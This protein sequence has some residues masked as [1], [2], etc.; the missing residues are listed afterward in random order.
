MQD[1]YLGL[2]YLLITVDIKR[3]LLEAATT[4]RNSL[5]LAICI[6]KFKPLSLAAL[7]EDILTDSVPLSGDRLAITVNMNYFYC[8]INCHANNSLVVGLLTSEIISLSHY[9]G[10]TGLRASHQVKLSAIS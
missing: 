9:F 4:G 5:R 1:D 2:S 3:L 7:V 10:Q 8:S 6:V